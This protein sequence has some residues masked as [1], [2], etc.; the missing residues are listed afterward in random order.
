[1]RKRQ[2]ARLCALS[3][4]IVLFC[5]QIVSAQRVSSPRQLPTYNPQTVLQQLTQANV[6]YLGETHNNAEDHLIQLQIIEELHRQNP[7]IAIAMEMFQRPFQFQLDRYIANDLTERQLQD[8][9]DYKDRWGY[10]WEYYAPILRFAKANRLP[11]LAMNTPTEITRKVA[12]SGLESLS[13]SEQQDIPPLSEIRTDNPAYRQLMLDIYQQ[14]HQGVGGSSNS[15]DRFFQAQVLWD[16]TMA[17]VIAKFLRTNPDFQV[18][19][20][21]GQGHIIYGHGIPTRVAR[22]LGSA[23]LVQRTVLLNPSANAQFKADES[24][25]D[26]IWRTRFE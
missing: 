6:V 9:T 11:V 15:F 24:A 18:V 3:L 10:P 13:Q 21:V 19:A 17:E 26:F 1:M 12:R 14:M 25:A 8:R 5:T 20:I 22:R 4:G 16:E 7:N 2:I 23:N